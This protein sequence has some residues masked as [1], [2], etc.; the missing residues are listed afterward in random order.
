MTPTIYLTI[1]LAGG[2]F[3]GTEHM[4]SLVPG[5]V[6]TEV[7]YANSKVAN[8][9]YKEVCTGKTDAAETVKVVFDPQKVTLP[10]IL[11]LYLMSV[12]P[13]SVNRQGNDIGTQY[14]TGIYYTTQAEGLVVEDKLKAFAKELGQKPAIESGY[15]ENFFPAEEYHQ[16]YLDKN[17]GGY[18][19][20]DPWLFEVARRV[21]KR[22]QAHVDPSAYSRPDDARLRSELT[23]EQYAVTQR[24]ATE[25]PF[26]NEYFD[27]HEKGIYVDVTTGEPLF[28]STDKFDSGCGWPSFSRP[29][30]DKVIV[31]KRDLSHGMDRTEVRSRV[32]DAHLGHVFPDGPKESGGLRYCI[33]SASLRFIPL[34]RMAA[35]GYGQYIP[36]VR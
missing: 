30:S 1:Y 18:C 4:F 7:G 6:S 36:L 2:C 9:T 13:L 21:T 22:P 28:V 34:N 25:A 8:P 33:N 12:D 24:N 16:E 15:L 3:W 31:E 20:I 17:P 27:N 11:D 10:Q 32:G 29:V 5:V 14:R 26:R 23:A 19:H 35:E